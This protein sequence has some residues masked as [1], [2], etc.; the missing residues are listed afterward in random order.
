MRLF[1]DFPNHQVTAAAREA[2]RRRVIGFDAVKLM[3]LAR[4]EK[5]PA[6][7]DRAR[8]PHLPQPFVGATRIVDYASLL[9]GAPAHG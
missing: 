3:L 7:L 4:I 1:E 2:V 8:Y 5:R 9:A 6:H